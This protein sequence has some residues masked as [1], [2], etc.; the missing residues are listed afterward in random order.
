MSSMGTL[1]SGNHFAELQAVE[2]VVDGE[3][4]EAWGLYEGQLVAMIHSGS[5]GLG[6]QVCTDH[7]RH[8]ERQF[9]SDD[10]GWRHEGYDWWIPD[11]Q[12]AAA[13]RH[14][15]RPRHTSVRWV[16]RPTTPSRTGRSWRNASSPRWRPHTKRGGMVHRYDV[17]HNI[18]KDEEH[19][20]DGK[21]CM[22]SV[23]RKGRP[24]LPGSMRNSAPSTNRR[25]NLSSFQGTWGQVVAAG[26]PETGH[27]PGF[28]LVLPWRRA[29]IVTGSSTRPSRREGF[30][31]A[32]PSLRNPPQARNRARVGRGS[33]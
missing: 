33:A 20:I 11:R 16:L 32:P 12:L 28:W 27:E 26:R 18:A 3:T 7:V 13:P 31:G 30:E 14:S 10:G 1:G 9:V 21:R 4:A 6:H 22:C 15:P 23:H 2:E 17:A 5:R 8:L 25:A 19:V 29:P 24:S